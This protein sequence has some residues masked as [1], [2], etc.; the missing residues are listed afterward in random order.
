MEETDP[1]GCQK[2]EDGWRPFSSWLWPIG[3]GENDG[4]KDACSRTDNI[5]ASKLFFRDME[6]ALEMLPVGDI[7]LLEHGFGGGL[8]AIG[9][10]GDQLLGFRAKLQIGED[11]IAAF[12][13]ESSSE[14]EI[15]AWNRFIG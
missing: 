3:R 11:D 1:G 13:Q 10:V 14:G 5:Y 4:F 12:T 6:H 7:G 8:G 15:D 9:V 2:L